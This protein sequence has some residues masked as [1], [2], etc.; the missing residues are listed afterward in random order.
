MARKA[1]YIDLESWIGV[2]AKIF[3]WRE[4]L[5]AQFDFKANIDHFNCTKTLRVVEEVLGV[6]SL[7]YFLNLRGLSSLEPK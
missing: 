4:F 7:A 5:Y 1:G 2:L 3:V 6:F